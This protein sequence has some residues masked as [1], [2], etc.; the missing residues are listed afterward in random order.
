MH[1]PVPTD[2]QKQD[3]SQIAAA[4]DGRP[5]G[6]LNNGAPCLA[7]R[8]PRRRYGVGAL[9]GGCAILVV[10]ALVL[11]R[12][13]LRAWYHLRAARSEIQRSH[14]AQAARH[15]QVCMRAWP[16]DPEVLL[17]AARTARCSGSYEEAELLLE[18]RR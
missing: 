17:L 3:A 8:R 15:L 16:K 9:L 2:E 5:V 4:D 14:Y 7:P 6:S 12:P 13:S 18:E 1:A 11:A 10:G